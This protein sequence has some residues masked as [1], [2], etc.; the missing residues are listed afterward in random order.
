MAGVL[1]LERLVSPREL[2]LPPL[3]LREPPRVKPNKLCKRLRVPLEAG[4]GD[5]GRGDAGG[6]IAAATADACCLR[7][8]PRGVRENVWGVMVVFVA[9][10]VVERGREEARDGAFDCGELRSTE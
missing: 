4:L 1:G 7:F 6:P 10:V 9:V 5:A 3:D 8:S 2:V